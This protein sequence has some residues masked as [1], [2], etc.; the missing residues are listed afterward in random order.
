MISE[1]DEAI[2]L[3]PDMTAAYLARGCACFKRMDYSR[4]I[5]DMDVAIRLK[6]DLATAYDIR[7]WAKVG[8][9]RAAQAISD[10]DRSLPLL[11]NDPSALA[12]PG[13]GHMRTGN[14]SAA[15]TDFGEALHFD[16][17]LQSNPKLASSLYGRPLAEQRKGDQLH[18]DQD[19]AAAKA[20]QPDIQEELARQHIWPQ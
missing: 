15:A 2:K 19:L 9:G 4:S 11:P 6:P 1:S 13:W 12:G 3:K 8:A 20:I 7:C 16:E 5:Q 14:Y 10:C 18:A 17:A